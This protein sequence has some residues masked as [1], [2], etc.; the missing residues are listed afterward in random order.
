MEPASWPLTGYHVRSPFIY[1]P[2]IQTLTPA[3]PLASL[4]YCPICY[5]PLVGRN[6]NIWSH[7][8][9]NSQRYGLDR[10]FCGQGRWIFH[11]ETEVL[12]KERGPIFNHQRMFRRIRLHTVLYSSIPCFPE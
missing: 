8:A 12:A 3:P 11:L 6:V 4:R 2:F 9:H 1:Q 7:E 5:L 10:L